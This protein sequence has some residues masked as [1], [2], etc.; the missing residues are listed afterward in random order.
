VARRLVRGDVD[1]GS[2]V[3]NPFI[4]QLVRRSKGLPVYV[5]LVLRDVARGRFSHLDE[6]ESRDLPKGMQNYFVELLARDGLG[7]THSFRQ[8]VLCFLALALE[9]LTTGMLSTF[10]RQVYDRGD[11]QAE[12]TKS[13]IEDLGGML[14]P[15][16]TADGETGWRIYHPELE[17]FIKRADE[18]S[19]NRRKASEVLCRLSLQWGDLTTEPSAQRYVLLFGPR[20]MMDAGDWTDLQAVLGSDAFWSARVKSLGTVRALIAAREL[21]ELLAR[22]GI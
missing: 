11:K 18:I 12:V 8:L 4:E 19:A 6:A 3:W 14:R 13:A 5:E 7:D 17:D 20:H 15:T 10:I 21:A 1:R 22:R 16:L 2:E 9:P